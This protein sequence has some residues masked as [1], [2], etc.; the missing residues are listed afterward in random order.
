MAGRDP[1]RNRDFIPD[2]DAIMAETEARSRAFAS[3]SSM[4]RDVRYGP[5]PRQRLDLVFPPVPD[6][7]AP[8][9]MFIHGGYWRAG[10]KDAHTLVAAPVV[11]AGGIAAIVGYDLMP[12][13]RLAEI[14]AQV[15]ASARHLVEIAPVIGAGPAHFTASGHSAGAH[16]ASLL[17][18]QAPGDAGPPD[19]PGLRAMLLVSGIYDLSG[20]PHSFLKDE[21]KMREDEARDWSPLQARHLPGTRRVITR[22]EAETAPFHHQATALSAL[23]DQYG[24]VTELRTEPGANHLT[25]VL[26]LADPGSSLG[27][28]LYD[29]VAAN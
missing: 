9:H 19:M 3:R 1:Y 5:T 8:L 20:I 18:A 25:I 24:Q 11:A 16:L 4:T 27:K 22:G 21:A 12:D 26:D 17:A 29:M 13:T 15:R 10:S 7:A 6:A 28:C 2:F 23:L 14:V